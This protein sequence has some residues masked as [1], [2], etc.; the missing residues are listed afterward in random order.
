MTNKQNKIQKKIS[1]KRI[2]LPAI[3]GLSVVAYMFY[4]EF[5]PNV[6]NL[7][8]FT[9]TTIIF[10][11]IS[12][13]LMAIK[14]FGYMLRLRILSKKKLSWRKIFNI[15]MLWEFASA[16]TPGAVGGTSI[17]VVFIH[18]EGVNVGKSTSIVMA[19]SFLAAAA[20]RMAL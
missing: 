15:I 8:S 1:P 12:L 14:D 17:A 20:W 7:L 10:V 4:K 6:F 13:I 2:I 9:W 18:K 11:F 5:E 3:L 16:I 19:T